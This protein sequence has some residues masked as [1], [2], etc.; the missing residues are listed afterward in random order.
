[1]TEERNL[2]QGVPQSTLPATQ[3]LLATARAELVP[4]NRRA[5]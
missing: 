1:M 3:Q 2:E 5:K 4:C